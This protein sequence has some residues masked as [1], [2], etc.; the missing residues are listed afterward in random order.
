M[1]LC[2]ATNIA[3]SAVRG[4]A[5]PGSLGSVLK[6]MMGCAHHTKPVRS[7]MWVEPLWRSFLLLLL[8]L[9]LLLLL[10]HRC[11]QP[12]N[13]LGAS[14]HKQAHL[15]LYPVPLCLAAA[16]CVV[17]MHCMRHDGCGAMQQSV[18]HAACALTAWAA[19]GPSCA[20]C[21]TLL[22]APGCT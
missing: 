15:L 20:V 16:P 10:L 12:R 17:R 4:T 14:P 11:L 13:V 7:H 6:N 22:R 3:C 2:S 18:G 5:E 1:T 21:C 8:R 19:G 9:L